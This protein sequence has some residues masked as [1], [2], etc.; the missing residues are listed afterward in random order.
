MKLKYE[1]SL[2]DRA[3]EISDVKR[4]PICRFLKNQEVFKFNVGDIVIKQKRHSMNDTWETEVI[5]GVRAPRKFMYVFENEV[6]IGYL[7]PLRVDGTGF[8]SELVMTANFDP[9]YVRFQL[10]PDYVDHMLIGDDDFEYN[11]SY[12]NKKAY[13]DEA[14]KNNKKLLVQ[15]KSTKK[16]ADWISNLKV[17][18]EFWMGDYFDELAHN[19]YRVM[20]AISDQLARHIRVEAVS[21]VN[22]T[23]VG[24]SMLWDEA[25]FVYRYVSMKQPYPVEDPLCGGQAR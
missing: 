15:T 19:K 11:Q 25:Y 24:R 8:T 17:G 5:P 9:D 21:N 4:N 16:R 1:K 12:V 6:G 7:K 18:D 13:R 20:E 22:P 10:D 14:I 3:R 2:D 23:M